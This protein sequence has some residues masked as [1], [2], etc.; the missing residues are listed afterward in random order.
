M[1]T[2]DAVVFPSPCV[3]TPLNRSP[4]DEALEPLH[5]AIS[6]T[7]STLYRLKEVVQRSSGTQ[8][9]RSAPLHRVFG[10]AQHSQRSVY[11]FVKLR[12]VI[13][14]AKFTE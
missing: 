13:M 8:Q 6:R 10:W 5:C 2:F 3:E 1:G 11:I 14:I 12:H 7:S 4:S 9:L